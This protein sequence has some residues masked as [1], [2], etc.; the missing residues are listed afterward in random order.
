[1]PSIPSV[2]P[3]VQQVGRV[4]AGSHQAEPGRGGLGAHL[5]ERLQQQVEPLAVDRR[6]GEEEGESRALMVRAVRREQLEV[7][8]QRH[9][10]DLPRRHAGVDVGLAG[11]LRDGEDLVGERDLRVLDRHDPAVEAGRIGRAVQAV[12]GG[13]VDRR[14]VEQRGDPS[15]AGLAEGRQGRDLAGDHGVR[16]AAAQAPRHPAVEEAAGGE[17]EPRGGAGRQQG[18]AQPPQGRGPGEPSRSFGVERHRRVAG[19]P[20]AQAGGHPAR[21]LRHRR[22]PR[23]VAGERPRRLKRQRRLVRVLPARM[24]HQDLHPAT[25][26]AVCSGSVAGFSG[27]GT[28]AALVAFRAASRSSRT[29]SIRR[30][31]KNQK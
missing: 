18:I 26:T 24:G 19:E 5:V 13:V 28:A 17:V 4:A 21:L 3:A 29:A 31:E 10:V 20:G 14:R 23:P 2:P 15:P 22:H 7:G 9:R 8:S 25:G 11:E 16:P 6:A 1:M 12:L 27:R 30:P